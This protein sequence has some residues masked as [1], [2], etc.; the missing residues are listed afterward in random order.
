MPIIKGVDVRYW[1]KAL[2]HENTANGGNG[3][4]ADI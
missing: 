1:P 2:I 4:F 3:Q